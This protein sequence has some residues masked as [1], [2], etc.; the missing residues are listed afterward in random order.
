MTDIEVSEEWF[1]FRHPEK[2][3]LCMSCGAQ[4]LPHTITACCIALDGP[5]TPA[6]Y[7]EYMGWAQTPDWYPPKQEA[8]P[9]PVE[10]FPGLLEWA[11]TK[12][13]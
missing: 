6:A 8:A 4:K 11:Q 12:T 9:K 2:G 5:K 10:P 7:D 1:V 3:W 13:T